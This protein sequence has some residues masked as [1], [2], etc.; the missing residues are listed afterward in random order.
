M[1]SSIDT[2]KMLVLLNLE[3]LNVNVETEILHLLNFYCLVL[4]NTLCPK[5]IKDVTKSSV[6]FKINAR[7]TT[8]VCRTGAEFIKKCTSVE[9][10]PWPMYIDQACIPEC[11]VRKTIND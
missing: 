4:V 9:E 11:L 2:E 6:H 10:N 3:V 7:L 8:N 1:A 5:I